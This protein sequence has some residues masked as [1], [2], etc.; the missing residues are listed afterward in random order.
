MI[1]EPIIDTRPVNVIQKVLAM[2]LLA[3]K[4][5]LNCD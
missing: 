5:Q 4:M 3:L 1:K 2:H